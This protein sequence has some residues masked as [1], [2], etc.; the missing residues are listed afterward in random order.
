[1]CC[2]CVLAPVE[3]RVSVCANKCLSARV[4]MLRIEDQTAR[5]EL[6]GC[7]VVQSATTAAGV[8]ACAGL[9]VEVSYIVFE[10]ESVSVENCA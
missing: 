3:F 8:C 1:M 5:S 7:H 6:R 10:V 2:V 9:I 4:P